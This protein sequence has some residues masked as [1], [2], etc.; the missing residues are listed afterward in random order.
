[1][2]LT[3]NEIVNPASDANCPYLVCKKFGIQLFSKGIFSLFGFFPDKWVG[4]FYLIPNDWRQN[5]LVARMD[6][7]N[8]ESGIL[9]Q[10]QNSEKNV[11][12]RFQMFFEDAQATDSI[13]AFVA[14]GMCAIASGSLLTGSQCTFDDSANSVSTNLSVTNLESDT[15]LPALAPPSFVRLQ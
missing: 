15:A 4:V 1:M 14:R 9:V 12:T 13:L 2:K 7:A 8:R 11:V 6:F 3:L 10:M 5:K